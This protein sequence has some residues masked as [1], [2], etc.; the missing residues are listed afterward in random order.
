MSKNCKNAKDRQRIKDSGKNSILC[1]K[2]VNAFCTFLFH[3]DLMMTFNIFFVFWEMYC[4]CT[5][6]FEEEEVVVGSKVSGQLTCLEDQLVRVTLIV[7]NF[8]QKHSLTKRVV[9]RP[10]GVLERN[11]GIPRFAYMQLIVCLT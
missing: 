7:V 8:G 11:C 9:P 10:R 4:K 3:I 2:A 6:T 5:T 1:A